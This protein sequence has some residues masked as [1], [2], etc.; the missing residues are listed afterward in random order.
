MAT[1]AVELTAGPV[2]AGVDVAELAGRMC[3]ALNE[4]DDLDAAVGGALDSRLIGLTAQVEAEAVDEALHAV[5]RV[6]G[7]VSRAA[8]GATLPVIRAEVSSPSPPAASAA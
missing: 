1:Y 6:F 7:E 3:E 2:D 5:V 8:A 4:R